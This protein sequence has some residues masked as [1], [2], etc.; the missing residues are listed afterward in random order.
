[1][2]KR[3]RERYRKMMN[4]QGKYAW[5]REREMR[6]EIITGEG[7]MQEGKK[8]RERVGEEGRIRENIKKQKRVRK[9]RNR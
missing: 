7:N 2:I 9:R 1:M 3:K 8:E 4:R 6:T 5:N